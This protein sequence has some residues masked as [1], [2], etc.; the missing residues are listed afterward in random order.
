MCQSIQDHIALECLLLI[1]E[2]GHMQN[3]LKVR[4]HVYHFTGLNK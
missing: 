1:V 3:T 4:S 2:N